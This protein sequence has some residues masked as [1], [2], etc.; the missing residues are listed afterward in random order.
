MREKSF[1]GMKDCL[2]IE[3]RQTDVGPEPEVT[4]KGPLR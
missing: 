1:G 2:G 3:S 4:D